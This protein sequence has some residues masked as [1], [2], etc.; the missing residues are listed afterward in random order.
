MPRALSKSVNHLGR[1]DLE[2]Q[3]FAR[4]SV[5]QEVVLQGERIRRG[6][7]QSRSHQKVKE[8]EN[9]GR[10]WAVM[11]EA[12]AC[13]VCV[14]MRACRFHSNWWDPPQCQRELKMENHGKGE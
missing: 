4:G 11:E 10:R 8:W 9:G 12:W 6:M 14:C 1:Q 13:M 7:E 5:L 3:G 2:G